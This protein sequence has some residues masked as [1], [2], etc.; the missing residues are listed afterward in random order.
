MG[1]L[2][3]INKIR[4]HFS[5]KTERIYIQNRFNEY[6]KKY[7]NGELPEIPLKIDNTLGNVWGRFESVTDI[8][9]HSFEP[10]Q[11][12]LVFTG[13]TG[14]KKCFCSRNGTLLGLHY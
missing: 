11:I 2:N 9:K 14:F 8:L 4:N 12:L 7:F 13:R 6:N 5:N 10:K 3:F 1:L